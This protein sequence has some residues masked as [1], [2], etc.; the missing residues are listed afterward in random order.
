[1]YIL[2][3]LRYYTY[4]REKRTYTHTHTSRAGGLLHDFSLR[5]VDPGGGSLS[6]REASGFPAPEKLI[7]ERGGIN[8]WNVN[9]QGVLLSLSL[10]LAYIYRGKEG[11]GV[12]FRRI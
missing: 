10:F 7:G 11:M 12:E 2:L 3:L 9:G 8:M 6:E 5:R 1:M 4:S